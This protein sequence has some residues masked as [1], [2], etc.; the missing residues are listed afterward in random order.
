MPFLPIAIPY[1][2]PLIPPCEDPINAPGRREGRAAGCDVKGWRGQRVRTGRGTGGSRERVAPASS[3]PVYG[4]PWGRRICRMATLGSARW[5]LLCEGRAGCD[6]SSSVPPERRRG[7]ECRKNPT[8]PLHLYRPIE[9]ARSYAPKAKGRSCCAPARSLRGAAV[10]VTPPR[11]PR[12][13]L[14]ACEPSLTSSP[15]RVPPRCIVT[16]RR[17]PRRLGAS[18]GRAERCAATRRRGR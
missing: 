5:P 7:R 17:E 11:L 16:E 4:G 6:G 12:P 15:G 1:G 3:T 14:S 2:Y 8:P 13:R 9:Q 18:E 10:V